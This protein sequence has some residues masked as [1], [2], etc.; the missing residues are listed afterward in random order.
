MIRNLNIALHIGCVQSLDGDDIKVFN[1]SGN[2]T[3]NEFDSTGRTIK[4]SQIYHL[5]GI[6]SN[7][8]VDNKS[9]LY[10][11]SDINENGIDT[12]AALGIK[13]NSDIEKY[14]NDVCE[15]INEM[16]NDDFATKKDYFN[17]KQNLTRLVYYLTI[18]NNYSIYKEINIDSQYYKT[19]N[20]LMLMMKDGLCV[21]TDVCLLDHFINIVSNNTFRRDIIIF[22]IFDRESIDIAHEIEAFLHENFIGRTLDEIKDY[23]DICPYIEHE[24]QL[25]N[26]TLSNINL[27]EEESEAN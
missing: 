16:Y 15:Y 25:H 5:N 9:K 24:K 19:V 1:Y 11:I 10:N 17:L 22:H 3:I 4:N 14:I 6:K 12:L 23:Y 13:V 18:Y 7:I 2:F 8:F 27:D 21:S 26:D 20:V